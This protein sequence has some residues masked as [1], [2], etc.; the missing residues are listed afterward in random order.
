MEESYSVQLRTLLDCASF[1]TYI[2]DRAAQLLQL[3][4]TNK[5]L[6][7]VKGFNNQVTHDLPFE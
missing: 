4:Q 5:Q 6:L 3:K 2:T 7:D 1:R